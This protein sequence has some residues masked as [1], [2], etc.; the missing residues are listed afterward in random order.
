M[1]AKD[2][3]LTG[4]PIPQHGGVQEVTAEEIER[5]RAAMWEAIASRAYELFERR[6]GEHGSHMEDWLEAERE[7]TRTLPWVLVEEADGFCLIAEIPGFSPDQIRLFVADHLLMLEAHQQTGSRLAGLG[8]AQI[9][10]DVIQFIPIPEGVSIDRATLDV[11]HGILQVHLPAEDA[12]RPPRRV[13]GETSASDK[14][15]RAS[16]QTGPETGTR[17]ESAK[18]TR[19]RATGKAKRSKP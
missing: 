3:F 19:K 13:T 9:G 6:G 4:T 10:R 7:L 15:R 17:A 18:A 16:A 5:R 12:K 11:E 8:H 1:A 14:S 2:I